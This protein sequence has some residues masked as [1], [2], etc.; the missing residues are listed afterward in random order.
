VYQVGQG[1]VLKAKTFLNQALGAACTPISL[2]ARGRVFALD[3]G[4]LT[5][6]GR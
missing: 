6:L 4:E 5:V 2:D 3:N 1:G